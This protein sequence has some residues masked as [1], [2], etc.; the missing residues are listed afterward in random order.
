MSSIAS[1]SN[2]ST[3]HVTNHGSNSAT[4]SPNKRTLMAMNRGS[5]TSTTSASDSSEYI[6]A[7][8][9]EEHILNELLRAYITPSQGPGGKMMPSLEFT[10]RHSLT[11]SFIFA[12]GEGCDG[13][14]LPHTSSRRS[15]Y[16]DD[17]DE[18]DLRG[19]PSNLPQKGWVSLC[20]LQKMRS[21]DTDTPVVI[22]KVTIFN[23]S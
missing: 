7:E 2:I 21:S 11:S 15:N 12:P 8:I 23:P 17:E 20:S 19:T 22:E 18:I 5:F 10:D 4:T 9:E 16:D 3:N 14:G 1:I 6:K 13:F